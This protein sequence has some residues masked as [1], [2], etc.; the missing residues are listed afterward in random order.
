MAI[1]NTNVKNESSPAVYA[2]DVVTS[3][4]TDLSSTTRALYIGVGGNAAV[5]MPDGSVVVFKNL[6]TGSILPIRAKRVN[7]IDTTASF[8]IALY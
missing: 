2:G 7:A 4:S 6:Q 1:P 5:V 8:I 3:D